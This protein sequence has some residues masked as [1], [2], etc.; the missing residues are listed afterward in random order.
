M[1]SSTSGVEDLF[2]AAGA[3]LGDVDGRP[4]AA[5]GQVA[6]EHQFHVAGPFEL[7]EDGVVHAA[8]GF[9]QGG[10]DDGQRAP[11]VKAAGRA[12][13]LLRNI[14]GSD[15]EAAGAGAAGIADPFVEGPGRAGDAVQ[16]HEH[17]AAGFG[18]PLGPFEDQAG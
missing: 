11:F 10:G 9:D 2:L 7:L 3:G 15:V 12:E 8:A 17:I 13:H 14:Q 16:Q 6:A 5:I 1:P 4:D 18:H